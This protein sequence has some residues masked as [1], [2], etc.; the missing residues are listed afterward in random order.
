MWQSSTEWVCE[1]T[2]SRY[3]YM[4]PGSNLEKARSRRNPKAAANRLPIGWRRSAVAEWGVILDLF[5]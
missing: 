5:G 2:R 1:T 3:Q 4:P